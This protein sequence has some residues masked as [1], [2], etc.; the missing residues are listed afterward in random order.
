M[1]RL[2]AFLLLLA[3][4]A[5]FA[6]SQGLLQP[7]GLGP[8]QQSEPHRLGQQI[9]PE[10][11]RVLTPEEA[12]RLAETPLPRAPE[13]LASPPLDDAA[14]AGLRKLLAA[15]PAG[16]WSLEAAVEPGRWI[17]YMGKYPT[18]DALEKKKSELRARGVAFEGLANPALEPG[19]SL[20]GFPTQA[21]AKEYLV[22]LSGKGIRTATVVQERADLRGTA[23][24]LPAVD[25]ALRVR[26]EELRPVLGGQALRTCR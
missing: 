2:T 16:S 4:A 25:D 1:L 19:L 5:W 17:A 13:C 7:W 23:L 20:G 10:A 6:W 3:N 9:R 15:W 8:A 22:A 14:V 24:R 18:R 12:R 21:A 26:L 11:V